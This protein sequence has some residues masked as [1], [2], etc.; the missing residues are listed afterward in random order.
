MNESCES[1]EE[2]VQEDDNEDFAEGEGDF[3]VEEDDEAQDEE[4][5]ELESMEE[6][7]GPVV[8]VV[9]ASSTPVSLDEPSVNQADQQRRPLERFY[10]PQPQRTMVEGPR[11]SLASI[12][13]PPTR[14]V[15]MPETP[16]GASRRVPA[17]PGSLG[18]PSRKFVP[19]VDDDDED[20]EE[21]DQAPSTPVKR[22]VNAALLA[23]VSHD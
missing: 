13:G 14:L 3:E 23:E 20:E 19:P 9:A 7:S 4:V 6:E 18:P 10:T 11:R 8:E 12:G 1:E 16:V 21:V 5:D 2:C 22:E 15:R 17:T